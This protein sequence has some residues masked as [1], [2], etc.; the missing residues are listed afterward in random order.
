MDIKKLNTVAQ[1]RNDVL[2]ARAVMNAKQRACMQY[3]NGEIDADYS[4][5]KKELRRATTRYNTLCA[6]LAVAQEA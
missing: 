3:A 1:L 6:D 4:A 5:L 2:A